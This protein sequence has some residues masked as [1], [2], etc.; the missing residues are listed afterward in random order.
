M[1]VAVGWFYTL[2][3]HYIEVLPAL[4]NEIWPLDQNSKKG[5]LDFPNAECHEALVD[6][7]VDD[8]GISA[9]SSARLEDISSNHLIIRAGPGQHWRIIQLD[10]PL[11]DLRDKRKVQRRFQGIS[12]LRRILT[13]NTKA[14]NG[15]SVKKILWLNKKMTEESMVRLKD[16]QSKVLAT[17]LALISVLY[18]AYAVVAIE[19]MLVWN[20][21]NDVYSITLTGQLIPFVIGVVGF[22]KTLHDIHFE[23]KVSLQPRSYANFTN[24]NT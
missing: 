4:K 14:G 3:K 6:F 17:A 7:L 10:R 15:Y 9:T 12:K 18:A 21:I 2:V 1:I 13:N 22:F 20:G 8:Y 5:L 16:S 24:I 11:P 19:L 23:L